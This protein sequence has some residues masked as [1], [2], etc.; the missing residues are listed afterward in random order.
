MSFID[1][2]TDQLS[3]IENITS[4][5]MFGGHGLYRNG[6]IFAITANEE[7][8]FKSD[9]ISLSRFEELGTRPFSYERDGKK[10]S[11]RY[12]KIP[13]DVLEDKSELEKW[14]DL[15]YDVAIRARK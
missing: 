5:R 11:M 6:L 1:F 14:C 15:S 12:W 4:R 2:V 7:L 3:D 8:Y 9:D 10:H 13:F